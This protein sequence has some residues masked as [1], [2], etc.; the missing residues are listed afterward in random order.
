MKKILLVTLA[1][2]LFAT[3]A[4]AAEFVPTK[5]VI[6][7]PDDPIIY[8]F[9]GTDV[10]ISFDLTGTPAAIWVVIET[11][12]S[13]AELPVSV[14]NGYLGW[15]VVNKIDSTV[16]ISTRN[17]KDPGAGQTITWNGNSSHNSPN[18]DNIGVRV[19]G[20]QVAPGQYTYYLWG[21]DD[22]TARSLV[23]NY[24]KVGFEWEC[25]YTKIYH[26]GEDGLPL[27]NP[28]IMGALAY[29]YS[30]DDLERPWTRNGTHYKWELGSDGLDPS[31]LEWSHVSEYYNAE[32]NNNVSISLLNYGAPVF[33]PTDFDTFYHVAISCDNGISTP[34]KYTFV[35]D[36]EAIIATD[37]GNWGNI[38]WDSFGSTSGTQT[39]NMHY[40]ADYLYIA[41]PAHV[42]ASVPQWDVLRI[43]DYEAEEIIAQ[44]QMITMFY[45]PDDP[46]VRGFFNGGFKG[47]WPHPDGGRK[48]L[49]YTEEFCLSY[50][51]DFTRLIEDQEDET[52]MVCWENNNGDVFLDNNWKPDSE[53]PWACQ[54]GTTVP[55]DEGITRHEQMSLDNY[56]FMYGGV[57]YHSLNSFVIFTPDGTGMSYMAFADDY[58]TDNSTEK[59]GGYTLNVGSPYDGI[60]H[61]G[62]LGEGIKE[63]DID[64]TTYAA[65]DNAR[66]IIADESVIAVED[67][68]VAKFSIDQNSPNP[69]NPTTTIGF[70]LVADGNVSI[71]IFNV[72]GQKIDTLVNDFMTAGKH[73][74]VWN[75]SGFSAGIYFYTVKSGDFSKTMKMTLLK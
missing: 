30:D 7:V 32:N 29:A 67:E 2:I 4:F 75:A 73:S 59:L 28:S 6:T 72:A 3:W 74:V 11:K 17:S 45:R 19:A 36:G 66:G 26:L 15:H 22:K 34:R 54:F 5:M 24:A 21:Y 53:E 12:L 23:S 68:E 42:S 48:F 35:P 33:D 38:T 70:N 57:S 39:E 10:D 14:R 31:K 52:D 51:A 41:S 37:W 55:R 20:G 46:T 58:G 71:D 60:Y 8:P 62:P 61:S 64:Y 1:M 49:C 9:D 63:H 16:Y 65:Y 69:F 56:G 50:L 43:I 47:L 44:K 27:A 13:D 25:N 40:D 18:I